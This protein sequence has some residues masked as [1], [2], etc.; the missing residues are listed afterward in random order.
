MVTIRNL[1]VQDV[2]TT[3]RILA[4]VAKG[5][6]MQIAG[7]LAGRKADPM[8]AGMLVLGALFTEAEDDVKS[9]LADLS[10]RSPDEFA[11]AP[12]A[13]LLDVVEQVLMQPDIRDFF[14]RVSRLVNLTGG[15]SSS[16]PSM[17]S[18]IDTDGPIA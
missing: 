16:T 9:L 12:A 13:E 3:A 14:G 8:E 11:Q 10:G 18:S 7:I 4:K 15:S 5:S 6:R 17:P 1:Q 2:F